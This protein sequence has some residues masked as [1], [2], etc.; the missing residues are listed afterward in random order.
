MS[1]S[2]TEGPQM[3]PATDAEVGAGIASWCADCSASCPHA[4]RDMLVVCR[5]FRAARTCD[6]CGHFYGRRL[7]EIDFDTGETMETVQCGAQGF[8]T[9]DIA[10]SCR[11][12]RRKGGAR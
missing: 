10:D 11:H 2:D 3:R 5:R 1:A 12:Y 7:Q 8:A 6:T 9:P 4:A